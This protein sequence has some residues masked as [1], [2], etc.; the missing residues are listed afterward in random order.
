MDGL[1]AAILSAK[2]PYLRAWNEHR[3]RV[4]ERYDAALIKAGFHAVRPT[5]GAEPVHHLYVVEVSNR[6]EAMQALKQNGIEAGIH[7]PIPLHLQPAFTYL[8]GRRGQCPVAEKA[9][10]RIVSL[11]IC[12]SIALET[13]DYVIRQFLAVARP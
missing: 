4:A 1:Q 10:G 11:P 12:G 5:D 9:A 3:R 13:V 6:D 2:L 8:G 7:Y